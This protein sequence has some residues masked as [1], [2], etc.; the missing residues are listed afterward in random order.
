ML[1]FFFNL[2]KKSAKPCTNSLL[3]TY[4]LTRNFA[5]AKLMELHVSASFRL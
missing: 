4:I 1:L 5:W 3:V 2:E